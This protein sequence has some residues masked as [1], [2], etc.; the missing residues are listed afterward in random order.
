[1]RTLANDLDYLATRLHARRSRMAEGD[2]LTALCR[3]RALPELE[4]AVI[5]GMEPTDLPQFHRRL[6]RELAAEIFASLKHLDAEDRELV[7]WLLV[8]FQVEN[9]KVLLRG[10][11]NR[12]PREALLPHLVPLPGEFKAAGLPAAKSL[13]EFA[14]RLPP[15]PPRNRLHAVLLVQRE[16]TPAFIFEAALDAGYFQE[17]LARSR[18]LHSGEAEL[19]QP[20]VSQETNLFE[21]MVILRGRFHF[22]LS[23]ETLSLLRLAG[24]DRPTWL[25]VAAAAP[26]A[27]S[28]AKG[29]VGSVI[30]SLPDT[31][32]PAGTAGALELA[33][34]ESLGWHRFQR[35]ANAVF[36]RSHMGIAAVAAYFALR[37]IEIANLVTVSEGLRLGIEEA[38]IRARLVPRLDQEVAHV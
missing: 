8:R 13:D 18:R 9:A 21:L 2:R 11:L 28:A 25:T 37:R 34:V 26:D 17:L 12:I 33:T 32:E 23:A 27:L 3:A 4:R 36:R 14:A 31:E 6:M 20:L 30:D 22:H 10:V 24:K 5:P 35:I 19:L 38:A 7:A 29:A 16:Q 15:G 1:M